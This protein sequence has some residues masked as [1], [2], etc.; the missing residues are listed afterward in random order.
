MDRLP[1][2]LYL[3]APSFFYGVKEGGAADRMDELRRTCAL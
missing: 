2:A 1:S 3:T